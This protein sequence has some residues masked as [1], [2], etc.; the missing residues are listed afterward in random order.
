MKQR[1]DI[2][3]IRS[4]FASMMTKASGLRDPKMKRAF[5][6]VLREDYLPAGP[7]QVMVGNSYLETPSA[8]PLYLYQNNLIAL[9][10]TKGINN[11]EPFLHASWIGA[12]APQP[13]ETVCH[14][15]A[16]T[17]YYSAILANLVA[18]GPVHAFEIDE[19]LARA[20]TLNVASCTN[21]TPINEDATRAGIPAC[22]LFY[23]NAGVAAPPLS[24]LQS[25]SES[26][27]MI[28]PWRPSR[29]V[30]LAIV[31]TRCRQGFRVKPIAP[32]WFIPC[33]GASSL[34][35]FSKVPTSEQAWSTRSAWLRCDRSPDQSATAIC[36]HV[37]FSTDPIE[38]R[39]S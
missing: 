37:W 15:G 3:E 7:W 36:E 26:G 19:T 4:F 20:A 12:A 18:P 9:D 5:E 22:D 10:V 30:G 13:G 21:V 32:A 1:A 6:T 25:L 33:I 29:W 16:G 23:V 38:N 31:L 34:D 28:I 11:G 35:H 2:R 24:W 8:D 39:Q 17:G 27:R 14:V